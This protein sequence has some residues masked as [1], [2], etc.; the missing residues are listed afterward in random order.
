ME[1]IS[2]VVEGH[3][4]AGTPRPPATALPGLPGTFRG[5]FLASPLASL[6]KVFIGVNL[7]SSLRDFSPREC[8]MLYTRRILL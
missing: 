5:A 4:S 6:L 1:S 3:K 8:F 7:R 2:C